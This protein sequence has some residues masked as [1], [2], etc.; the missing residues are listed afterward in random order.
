MENDTNITKEIITIS[1]ELDIKM[2]IETINHPVDKGI[3]ITFRTRLLPNK[4][5]K[6]DGKGGIIVIGKP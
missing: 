5:I 2:E 6:S 1:K 3:D 4:W